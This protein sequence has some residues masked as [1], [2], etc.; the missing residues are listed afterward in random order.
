M[1]EQRTSISHS[2]RDGPRLQVF[3]SDRWAFLP[4]IARYIR[5]DRPNSVL[6][7]GAGIGVGA[8]LLAALTRFV[9]D[10]V[11]LEPYKSRVAQ[12]RE[13][14]GVAAHAVQPTRGALTGG[15]DALVL[16]GELE[17]SAA[18]LAG[19]RNDADA[20]APSDYSDEDT[21]A[22]PQRGARPMRIYKL[23]VRVSGLMMPCAATTAAALT[24]L[25]LRPVRA[26]A[27]GA[28]HR[29]ER[30]STSSTSS[31]STSRAWKKHGWNSRSIGRR[32]AR[33]AAS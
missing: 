33:R 17:S 32:S 10:V 11:A 23:E 19:G 16:P 18:A 8:F 25:H 29:A 15:D 9:G 30:A 13:N 24:T 22:R 12:M 27:A 6:D 31:S 4:D 14:L 7:A 2:I 26:S 28:A 5:F 21:S 20:E 3:C 1:V